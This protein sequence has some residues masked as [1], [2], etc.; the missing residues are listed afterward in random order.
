MTSFLNN[1]LQ[2]LVPSAHIVIANAGRVNSETGELHASVNVV[3]LNSSFWRL[4]LAQ[5]SVSIVVITA[6]NLP[7]PRDILLLL[8]IWEILG[9]NI[10]P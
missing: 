7:R 3:I 1:L 6:S 10:G 5:T 4:T 8:H 9:S 2:K